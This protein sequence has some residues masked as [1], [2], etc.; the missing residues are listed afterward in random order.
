MI[1]C[2][3]CA[4]LLKDDAK[5]CPSCGTKVEP[6]DILAN[7][8]ADDTALKCPTC[9]N[10]IK[11]GIKF[12]PNC[13]TSTEKPKEIPVPA[14]IPENTGDAAY[15]TPPVSQPDVKADM[16]TENQNKCPDCGTNLKPGAKF[17][18]VCGKNLSAEVSGAA[19]IP[20]DLKPDTASTATVQSAQD[21]SSSAGTENKCPDCGATLKP[22]AKFCPVCGKNISGDMPVTPAAASAAS[23]NSNAPTS[24]IPNIPMNQNGMNT[25]SAPIPPVSPAPSASPYN[26]GAAGGTVAA[27]QTK[28]PFNFKPLI[29]IGAAV[30]V[31]VVAVIVILNI[32]NRPPTINLDD[33]LSVEFEGYNGYG[34]VSVVF[35]DDKFEGDW[36]DKLQYNGNQSSTTLFGYSISDYYSAAESLADA[37]KGSY[38]VNKSSNL[39]NGDKIK[40]KWSISD[41]Q[42]EKIYQTYKC[43]LQFSEKE[44][45]VE[46]LS[47]METV[48]IFDGIELK[49]SGQSPNGTA[50]ICS[51]GDYNLNYSIDKDSGLSNGDKI[52]VTA[53]SS[54]GDVNDY[55]SE[56]YK[57]KTKSTEKEFTV[58]GLPES[59]VTVAKIPSDALEKLK[60][61][62]ED[63]IKSDIADDDITFK[64]CEYVGTILLNPK[65][66][67]SWSYE[68]RETYIIYKVNVTVDVTKNNKTQKK[69]LTYY[70]YGKFGE[71]SIVDGTSSYD[72]NGD[73]CYNSFNYEDTWTYINGYE[74]YSD[75]FNAVVTKNLANYTYDTD[76]NG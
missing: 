55:L 66:T 26:F 37:L 42:K 65:D 50:D 6:A 67:D 7:P 14:P 28:K 4:T 38:S 29:I 20:N 18:P 19:P 41:S 45:T 21:K 9:G 76:I 16:G 33:Y 63:Y 30:V 12:C 54:Y 56:Y 49:Y 24:T 74:E 64:N 68:N 69:D 10:E 23:F 11:P 40:V 22:G 73:Y 17:C 44:F 13:G 15:N 58:S 70:T 62:T 1:R 2:K 71:I 75:L 36:K 3:K 57:V 72:S 5:F 48:D 53:T 59:V 27:T 60:S 39:S 47:E 34:S 51:Y 32:V 46:N 43:E 61:E 25:P 31:V 8:A 35:D 52:K